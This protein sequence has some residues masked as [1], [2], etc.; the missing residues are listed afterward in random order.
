MRSRRPADKEGDMSDTKK[1]TKKAPK[2]D[3]KHE[4][5]KRLLTDYYALLDVNEA[6]RPFIAK[7]CERR[8][9][10]VLRESIRRLS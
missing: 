7:D 10:E 2:A 4:E 9:Q 6:D 1:K 5:T 8:V 3:I